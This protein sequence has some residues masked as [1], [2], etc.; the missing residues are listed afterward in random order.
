MSGRRRCRETQRGWKVRCVFKKKWHP[1]KSNTF[2]WQDF[3]IDIFFFVFENIIETHT[4]I[5]GEHK[6]GWPSCEHMRS[7]E[8]RRWQHGMRSW[9][10][11]IAIP[12][13]AWVGCSC[14]S[15]VEI[16]T[17]I[18]WWWRLGGDVLSSVEGDNGVVMTWS[19]SPRGQ[20]SSRSIPAIR[21]EGDRP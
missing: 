14:C 7:I 2:C 15:L 11:L 5:Q 19:R 13:R 18:R 20:G 3:N 10:D 8:G 12:I 16:M 1:H 6:E 4:E 17:Q 21:C 9:E